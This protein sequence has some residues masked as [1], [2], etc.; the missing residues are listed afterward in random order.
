MYYLI[1]N[2]STNTF[3]ESSIL[4]A[5]G[6]PFLMSTKKQPIGFILKPKEKDNAE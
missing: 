5:Q 6:N 2:V 3:R 1:P 4:D